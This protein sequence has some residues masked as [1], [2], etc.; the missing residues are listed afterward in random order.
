MVTGA[1]ALAAELDLV[2]AASLAP[3]EVLARLGSGTGGLSSAEAATRLASCGPNILGIHRVR[4]SAVLF[5]QVTNPIADF[6][7]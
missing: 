7:W 3:Q 6:R 1:H 2:A 5:S 4:V